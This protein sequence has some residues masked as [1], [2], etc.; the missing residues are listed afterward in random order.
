M[1]AIPEILITR[2]VSDI[3]QILPLFIPDTVLAPGAA[4]LPG[5]C[6]EWELMDGHSAA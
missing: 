4:P 1:L 2:A 6:S 3:G 5:M